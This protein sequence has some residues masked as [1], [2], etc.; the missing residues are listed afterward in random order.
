[1]A[2]VATV[3]I[4]DLGDGVAYL[5]MLAVDPAQQAG[6]LGRTLIAD[7]QDW[8]ARDFA[9]HTMRMTVISN[10]VELIAYYIRRGYVD[11]GRTCPFPVETASHLSMVVLEKPIR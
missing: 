3:S 9:A 2:L 1:M 4:T 8:A 11:T 6:G 7:A 5:G 10:R